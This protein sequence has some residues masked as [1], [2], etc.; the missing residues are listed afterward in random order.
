MYDILVGIYEHLKTQH[1][2]PEFVA[3]VRARDAMGYLLIMAIELGPVGEAGFDDMAKAL[4]TADMIIYDTD[5]QTILRQVFDERGI[6]S[7]TEADVHLQQL[8][9]LPDLRLPENINH[10]L[11]AAIFLEDEIWLRSNLP[12][13][14]NSCRWEPTVIRR[15]MPL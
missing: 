10:A 8:A 6:L 4:L 3:L 2:Q 15:D 12:Q 7:T 5:Y 9:A 14:T 11:A 1:Q 13:K